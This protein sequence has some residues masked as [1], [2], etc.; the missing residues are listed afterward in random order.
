MGLVTNITKAVELPSGGNATIR[1]LSW[2]QMEQAADL[3]R[4]KQTGQM[5]EMGGEL[6]KAIIEAKNSKDAEKKIAELQDAQERS[7]S[8]YDRGT[9]LTLG[10]A[11]CDLAESLTE[12]LDGL[13]LPDA[14]FLHEEIVSYSLESSGKKV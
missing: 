8:N 2:K 12:A 3:Q 4:S 6:M 5:K 1:R 9:V 10:V 14:K 11:S 7:A 13:N